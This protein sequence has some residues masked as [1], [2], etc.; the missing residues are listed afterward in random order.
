MFKNETDDNQELIDCFEN[1]LPLQI[2][3]TRWLKKFNGLIRKSFKKVRIVNNKKKE[4]IKMKSMLNERMKNKQELK[5][6]SITEEIKEKIMMRIKQIEED[7]EREFTKII[8]RN[9][10][11]L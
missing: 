5:K 8:K 4:N 1:D 10:L 11:K 6:S 7:I 2:Q 9:S 3:S